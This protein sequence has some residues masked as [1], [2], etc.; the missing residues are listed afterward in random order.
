[1]APLPPFVTRLDLHF[2]LSADGVYSKRTA[3]G[4]RCGVDVSCPAA[5]CDLDGDGDLSD[6]EGC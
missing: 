3:D 6:E 2:D 5:G 4:G 1:M